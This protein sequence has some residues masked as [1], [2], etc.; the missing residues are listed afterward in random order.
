MKDIPKTTYGYTFPP[1]VY[2]VIDNIFMLKSSI[3]KEVKVNIAIDDVRLR[4]N[5][6]ITKTNRLT[7]KSFFYIILGFT[8]SRLGELG[9]IPSFI[10]L[11]P[12]TYKRVKPINITGIDKVHLKAD[13][14][15]G[16]IVNGICEAILYSLALSSPPRH[17]I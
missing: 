10:Q 13:C 6:T 3:P 7:K 8:Q 1:G 2:E 12:G 17:K 4:S 5:L 16:S 14:I 9:D 15:Q 11:I